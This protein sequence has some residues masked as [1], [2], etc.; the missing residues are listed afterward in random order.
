MLDLNSTNIPIFFFAQEPVTWVSSEFEISSIKLSY[1][2]CLY[3]L[4]INIAVLLLS[5]TSEL[6]S[7]FAAFL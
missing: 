6:L 7:T 4:V 1:V 2:L 5:L 3:L